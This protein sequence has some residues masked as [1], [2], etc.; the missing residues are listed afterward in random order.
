MSDDNWADIV[1]P[2]SRRLRTSSICGMAHVF[3]PAG[4]RALADLLDGMGA[5]L[6]E[7][8]KLLEQR[9]AD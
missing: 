6:D 5:K 7:A 9:K 1:L 4:A 8:R 2:V 3:N